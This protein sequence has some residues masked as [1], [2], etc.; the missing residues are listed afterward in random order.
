MLEDVGTLGA[1]RRL[2]AGE[3][4][5]A[6]AQSPEK[7]GE[8]G[9]REFAS[10]PG[11]KNKGVAR[12]GHPEGEAETI[13]ALS[14]EER[15]QDGAREA[16]NGLRGRFVYPTWP[17]WWPV[18]WARMAFTETIMRPLVWFL[19]NP[20]VAGP[21]APLP[22][23]PMLIVANHVTTYDAPLVEYALPGR[24]RRRVAAAMMGE[25]LEDYRHWRN[26]E[27]PPGRQR[28]FL[29]GPAAYFL[30]TA[31]FNVFPLPRRRDFQNSFFHAGKAMD[32]GY[33]VLVFPEGTRTADGRLARFRPGIG[34]LV[35]QSSVPVLPVGIRGLG[36]LKVKGKGWFRSGTI[37]VRVGEAIEFAPEDTEAA[38]TERL[39]AEVEKLV[40]TSEGV[41]SRE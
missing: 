41:G 27:A 9:T 34:L 39:R 3:A 4:E 35:K 6:P 29:F 14:P 32:R 11:D 13:S 22:A 28:F 12:V 15:R 33:N 16:A 21:A 37:E 40:G 2:V 8:D 7:S 23:G 24:L 25:M 5:P 36:A 26:P 30:V 18:E 38:I 1:L 10:H 31:L 20:R 19:A 17:W